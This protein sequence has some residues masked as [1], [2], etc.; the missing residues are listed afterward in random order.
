MKKIAFIT[1]NY[2]GKDDTIALL[3]SLDKL[4]TRN[5]EIRLIVVDNGSGDGSVEAVTKEFPEVDLLQTGANL[6][7]TGG[8]NRGLEYAM[9]WGAD[10]FLVINND[11]L[12]GS[13]DILQ[14]LIETAESDPEAGLVVP[15]IYF[16]KGYEFHKDRYKE[17]DLGKVL[18]Y[19][20]GTVD[21]KN[22]R[23]NHRGIDEVDKGQYDGVG[24][25][26]VANGCCLLIKKEVI[27]KV[28]MF[29]NGLFGYYDDTDFSER[30]GR[31]GFKK[32]YDSRVFIFHK[33]SQTAGAGSPLSDYFITRNRLIFGLRFAGTRTNFALWREALKFLLFGRE[34]QRRGV[35]DFIKGVRGAPADIIKP[36]EKPVF[37]VKLSVVIVNYNTADLTRKLL[38]SLYDKK[39]G[40]D[41]GTSEII[42]LDN[43]ELDPC[44]NFIKEFPEVK[45][46]INKENSFFTRGYNRTIKYSRG[47]YIL[48]LNSDIE[49]C[50]SSIS[51]L[52]RAAE[53][54]QGKAVAGGR[55][56]FPDMSDQDSCFRLPTIFGAVG[57]YFLGQKGAYFM[58]LPKGENPV[59]VEGLV[60][61]CF[62][63]PRKVLD[64]VGLLDEGTYIFFEDIEYCRRL[65]RN[66]VPLYFYPHARFIH[67][68]GASTK[69]MKE[70]EAYK[71]LVKGSLHYH[72][73]L[74]YSILYLVMWFGQRFGRVK[75]PVAR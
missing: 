2:N 68:H 3:K 13:P 45:Y 4:N 32:F 6:G 28:E 26:G 59:R 46:I 54:Y 64:K 70:G 17:S 14:K 52:V 60:M 34:G 24:E 29:D 11:T 7:F 15:K 9:A 23:S 53:N 10:Y 1:V 19:A 30:V 33:V 40:F 20:G 5:Y 65:K 61:A 8:Y 74:Y 25:T 36:A 22:I 72:G 63:I 62:L 21:W 37:S 56:Y 57:E 51:E 39:S 66:N 18:W 35:W 73:R 47:E 48:L 38:L 44:T 55:L 12:L 42:L 41:R 43:G 31:A 69:Q 71:M 75:T 49:A 58:Y 27:E 16:A 50:R 67:H